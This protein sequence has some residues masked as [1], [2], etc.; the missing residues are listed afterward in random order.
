MASGL[1]L[2]ETLVASIPTPSADKVT[3][4]VNSVSGAPNWKDDAGLNHLF[5]GGII[6]RQIIT[7]TGAGTYTPTTGTVSVIIELVG[8]G[9]GGGGISQPGG[10]SVATARGGGGGGYI[11]HRLTS[12]FS[13]AAY[14]VGAKGTGGTAGNNAGTAGSNTTFTATGGGG[15]VYTAG[16]G[17]AGNGGSGGTP[18]GVG[19]AATAGG[20]CTNGD[21]QKPG[22]PSLHN[23]SLANGEALG[24]GG[25]SSHYGAG[26]PTNNG[27]GANASSAGSAGTGKGAGGSGAAGSGSGVARAGGDGTDGFII[28]T[29][30]SA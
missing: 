22:G 21:V 20:T 9:G 27:G 29:E 26:A 14:V 10:S 15:T 23:L 16:G 1:T 28:I 7:A 25:G 8:G 6:G 2:K 12:A 19:G 17:S 24:G 18:P 5:G 4:F 11:Q 13:G 30:F 3:L